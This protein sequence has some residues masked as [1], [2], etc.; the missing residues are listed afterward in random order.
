[1]YP[2]MKTQIYVA[3]FALMLAYSQAFAGGASLPACLSDSGE[4]LAVNNEQVLQWKISTP[5]QTLER[6]HVSGAFVQSYPDETGH[7]HF[8]IQIGPDSGDTLEVVSNIEF[9]ALPEL[10]PGDVIEACGDYIT[11]DAATSQYPISPD[12][13]IIHWIHQNPSGKG[14]PSGF[15]AINGVLYGWK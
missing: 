13:A 6:A 3:A 5:N 7:N 2:N 15:L 11:S 4:D 10:S 9:G 14:H 1:M 12:D 8:E